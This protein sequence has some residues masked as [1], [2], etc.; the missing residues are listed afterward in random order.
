MCCS[1]VLFDSSPLSPHVILE[2]A[3][4]G[5]EGVTNRDVHVCVS[6]LLAGFVIFDHLVL[7]DAALRQL[8]GG[9]LLGR[10]INDDLL[11]GHTQVDMDLK[12]LPLVVVPVRCFDNYPTAS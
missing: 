6:A 12:C 2:F 7:G 3:P 10:M 11:A 9:Q 5:V 8:H 1:L 4:R